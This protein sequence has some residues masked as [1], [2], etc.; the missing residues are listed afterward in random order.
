MRIRGEEKMKTAYFDCFSGIS[1]NMIIGA[2]LSAG[3]PFD[4]LKR[5]LSKLPIDNEYE[6]VTKSVTKQGIGACFF[7]VTLCANHSPH[8]RHLHDIQELI[9]QS[10]LDGEVKK[11]SL[12]IFQRLGL[13]EATVH[14][15]SLNE[16]HFHEVGGVD[17]IIDIVGAAICY[18]YLNIDQVFASPLH[19][20]CGMVKCAH[21]MMPV[22]APATALLL[23]GV[24]IYSTEVK[25][26]LVTPTGAAILTSLT[27]KFGS[28]PLL[29]PDIIG[30]GAG[31][32]DLPIPNLVRLY[33]GQET[34]SVLKKEQATILEATIDD[35][36]PEFYPFLMDKLFQAGAADVFLTPIQMKK[37]RPGILVTITSPLVNHQPILDVLFAESTTLGIRTHPVERYMLTRTFHT[38]ETRLGAVRVKAGENSA[39]ILN[40]TPEYE[41]CRLLA[42]KTGIPL[43]DIYLEAQTQGYQLLGKNLR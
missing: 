20:G 28:L 24:P 7:D 34:G 15:C 43:K 9:E 32:W 22:P 18:H 3:V 31:T 37:N 6:L 5:E 41:D 35:M 21:G 33:L 10:T 23:K 13:A 25:G 36:N 16:V 4:Y 12:K 8:S 26:E 40:I 19:V 39:G 14:G 11:L 1:G 27:D 30:Y 29:A 2:F 17:A 38:V 42:E